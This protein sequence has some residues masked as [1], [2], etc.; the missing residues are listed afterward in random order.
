[1]VDEIPLSTPAEFKEF[2]EVMC[3]LMIY[4]RNDGHRARFILASV[5]DPQ[6]RL[7]AIHQKVR[8]QISFVRLPAWTD[9]DV[10][11]LLLLILPRLS[12]S[13]SQSE[14]SAII[15]GA[16]G[17]PRTLKNILR[18]ALMFSKDPTWSLDRIIRDSQQTF[19]VHG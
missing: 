17:C 9:A 4:L 14:R 6:T 15:A 19:A 8:E 2:V 5:D 13:F 1:M 3:G 10:E 7:K 16:R 18:T 11:A 12:R